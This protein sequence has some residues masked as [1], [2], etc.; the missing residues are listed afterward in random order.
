MTVQ[1]RRFLL[2]AA[3]VCGF[4]SGIRAQGWEHVGKVDGVQ[5]RND[6][7]E[8]TSGKAKV[9]VTFVREG[10]VARAGGAERDIPSRSFL[11]HHSGPGA[12]GSKRTGWD[13]GGDDFIWRSR[14][15]RQ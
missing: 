7:V 6:G 14:S 5:K 13:R 1:A 3:L 10:I 9:R 12:T 8:L 15:P 11:G 2:V 4:S